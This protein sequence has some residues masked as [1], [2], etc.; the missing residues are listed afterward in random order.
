MKTFAILIGFLA[1]FACSGSPVKQKIEKLNQTVVLTKTNS[2]TQNH[3]K[4]FDAELDALAQIL[5]AVSVKDSSKVQAILKEKTI[6]THYTE[7]EKAWKGLENQKLIK[8]RK[9]RDAELATLN[10]EEHN[11]FYPFSG[12][13]LLNAY[14]LFPNCTN[15]LLFGLEK[16]G[17]LPKISQMQGAFLQNYLYNI[18]FALSEI[19]Q[20]NYFITSRMSGALNSNVKGILPI[21][22][23]FLARTN[24]QIIAIQKVYLDKNGK[25]TKIAF[26]DNSKNNT[27]WGLCIE[28]QNEQKSTSQFLYYFG[29]D[30]SDAAMPS[31]PELTAF[32]KSFS[33]KI[34]FLKSA[35]YLLHTANFITIRNLILTETSASVQDD[36]GV[37]Y[38]YFKEK[39]WEVKLYGKYA[40][41]IR[42]FSN[43][44]QE[45]LNQIFLTDKSIKPIDFTFGYH[46]W[47]DKS[48]IIYASKIK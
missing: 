28:F 47:T 37:P 17:E 31:K 26:A 36:T 33:S 13:D 23:V 41:P 27:L 25:A 15:Y 34:T 21:I 19:F 22:A 5:G 42:D 44:Y 8:M 10:Q 38:K 32:I 45:D 1:I 16:V 39:G 14:E 3:P 6:Q 2:T 29:T 7:F 40:R 46:W 30:L 4:I 18:R 11:L 48:S 24:N 35:S 9:W 20:R 43:G 12:P